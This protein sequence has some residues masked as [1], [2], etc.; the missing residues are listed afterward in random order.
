MIV[1]LLGFIGSG[2][3]TAGEILSELGFET[4]SF[5]GGVKDVT[6]EMFGWPRDLLEGNTDESRIWREQPDKFWSKRFGRDFTPRE[7]LQKM[8]TEVGR[9]I[10]HENFWVD[11]L[12][13]QIKDGKKYVITDC[14]F[15]NEIKFI[16]RMNGTTI[17]IKRGL[18]PHWYDIA[19][20]ANMGD[21]KAINFMHNQSG[22]HPSEW[23][24]IGGD[25]DHTIENDETLDDLKEKLTKCLRITYGS[26]IMSELK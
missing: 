19:H 9:S 26:S 13:G 5:A 14:R 7:A 15:F 22:V 3:G 24:W 8:G 6:S 25:I 1:G 4:L 17:E 12:E 20:K 21:I 18:K 11:R 23:S 16:H 10:F 2:K